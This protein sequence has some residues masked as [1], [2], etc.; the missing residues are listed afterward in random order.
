MAA[1]GRGTEEDVIGRSNSRD[2]VEGPGPH[3]VVCG[4][5]RGSFSQQ[6]NRALFKTFQE[7][8]DRYQAA[9]KAQKTIIA[10]E[11]VD[12]IQS[13]GGRFLKRTDSGNWFVVSDSQ[14]YRKVCHG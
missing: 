7:N 6:G 5:G 1:A 11:I 8:K 10:K 3:D 14:A 12:G 13:R 4:R 9:T 2:V